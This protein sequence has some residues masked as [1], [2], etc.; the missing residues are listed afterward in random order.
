MWYLVLNELK[1]LKSY[2]LQILGFLAVAILLFRT[3]A[4]QLVVTYFTVFPLVMAMTLPQMSF[5]QEERGKTFVFLRALPVRPW[6]I[7]AAKY[8]MSVLVLACFLILILFGVYYMPELELSLAQASTITLLSAFAG[9][10]SFLLHF[11]LGLKSA[12]VGLLV[13]VFAI[14]GPAMLLSQ[15]PSVQT[16]ISGPGALGLLRFANSLPGLLASIFGACMVLLISF[17][18]SAATFT[19][20][21][22]SQLR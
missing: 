20:R 3:R 2:F 21:D 16:W 11:L 12:K 15:N 19:R 13:S 4:P 9:S 17:A 14:G 18:L 22:I 6:Y 8:S 10:F 5:A 1:M 7:V